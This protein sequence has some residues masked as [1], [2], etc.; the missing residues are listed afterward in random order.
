MNS[1]S[2]IRAQSDPPQFS[3]RP[4]FHYF[5][6]ICITAFAGY[7]FSAH[8]IYG[9]LSSGNDWECTYNLTA[10]GVEGSNASQT[11]LILDSLFL[12]ALSHLMALAIL[13]VTCAPIYALACYLSRRH[14]VRRNIAGVFF[15]TGA[16]ILASLSLP[17]MVGARALFDPGHV[18]WAADLAAGLSFAIGG[19]FCGTAYCTLAFLHRS[20]I[21]RG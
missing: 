14:G 4:L 19:L 11:F 21:V 18:S 13:L 10:M 7:F 17:I 9:C 15:W 1:S 2:E 16:W 5:M 8:R 20:R 12:A 3:D 6:A